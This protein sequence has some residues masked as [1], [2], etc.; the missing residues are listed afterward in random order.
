[1]T[2]EQSQFLSAYFDGEGSADRRA[3]VERH[4]AECES[5]RSILAEWRAVSARLS[6]APLRAM[7]QGLAE[8]L[9]RDFDAANQD[10]GVLRIAGWLTSAA[11][12]VL[13]ASLALFP[14][15]RDSVA[16]SG[17]ILESTGRTA[18][19]WQTAAVMPPGENR[20]DAV[21]ETVQF[22][23]WMASDLAVGEQR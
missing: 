11:A 1:V 5:C 2:C 7:P 19:A 17:A 9:E 15:P 8:R 22:A 14:S 20:D 3:A 23:Q 12:A 18:V 6:A 16:D 4:L 13:V 10:R 21:P